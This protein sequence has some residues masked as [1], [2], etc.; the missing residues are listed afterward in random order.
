MKNRITLL[1][2]LILSLHHL[3]AQSLEKKWSKTAFSKDAAFLASEEAVRIAENVLLYQ[4]SNGGWGKNIAMQKVLSA[5]E[6]KE[7]TASKNNL[8]ETTI[9]NN[10]T[11]QELSF[12]SNIYRYHPN[13]SYRAAFLKG[14][15]FLLE[16]QYENGG[17]PQFYPLQNSYSSHI[18]YNDDAM[19]NVLFL[20]KKIMDERETY[21]VKIPSETLSKIEYS[22][23]KGIEIILKTQYKQNGKLTVWCAQHDEFSL[24]PAKARAYE[25][26]SLS[27][28]ESATLVLLLMS[29]EQPSTEVI[30]AVEHA[31]KWF[32][33]NKITGFKE[34]IVS[35]DKKLVA[36]STAPPIWG[37]FYDL[38]TNRIFVSDRDGIRKSS[39]DDIGF[40]RRNGY[41]WYTYEPA[42]V[43]KKYDQWKKKFV[44]TIPDK[45]YYIV[46]RDGSGDF[47]SIQ[48]AI[49]HCRSFPDERITLFIK[50]GTYHEKVKVPQWNTNI[51]MIGEA[52]D[53]TIISFDDYFDKADR[54]RNSTFFTATFS[55][56][57]NDII[58]ENLTI[59]NTAGEAGQA[60]GL[61]ITSDRVAVVN[62]SVIGNQDTLYLGNEGKIYI[63]DSYVEGT[64]DYIFGGATAYFEN[65]V[66]HSKKDSYITAP[67][68]PEGSE[69]GFVF[70][71]CRLTATEKV[72]KVYLGR[73]WRSF[74]KSVFLNSELTAAI[75]A[76][77]WHNWNKKEAEQNAYFAE[78][79]NS[80]EGAKADLRVKWS[81]QLSRK[82]AK[83]Y[84]K[85]HIL[86]TDINS[87]WYENL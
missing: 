62:C 8:K 81:H 11:V 85:Q 39:Y 32:R 12:L 20:F 75:A 70:N 78:F 79:R 82:E 87:N 7:I 67:S 42:A 47:E 10:A 72:T 53:H 77:G 84:N 33:Q 60:I 19:A 57:A 83:K 14:L 23:S 31:V 56:E 76:E 71:N 52:R 36:D 65:C 46:S 25:F 54:G 74:A 34:A 27:G 3:N 41:A 55:V 22:F 86:K 28:K 24:F 73:P 17:W 37:R 61:S 80:G 4:K 6:K 50:K 18:T 13:E 2:L 51:K 44:K 69:F 38:E 21:P 66:L 1:F 43:L 68:T 45:N 9:D 26:P 29:V 15:D 5:Q 58:L 49:D 40:E 64:T 59:R 30:N 16:A 35:G 48:N 63:K